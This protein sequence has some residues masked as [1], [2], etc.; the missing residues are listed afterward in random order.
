MIALLNLLLIAH[1]YWITY[2]FTLYLFGFYSILH[3]LSSYFF[4]TNLSGHPRIIHRDIKSSNILLD[5]N[6]EARVSY[7]YN[8]YLWCGIH[9]K[10]FY[11]V[12]LVNWFMLK[13]QLVLHWRLQLFCLSTSSYFLV[14]FGH[15]VS[16]FGLAKLALDS[17]THVTTRVMGTFG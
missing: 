16:D 7:F 14:W 1:S 11:E 6:Y 8:L 5:L 9:F 15:Q 4:L 3:C 2:V 13:C 10:I 17:N 12:C